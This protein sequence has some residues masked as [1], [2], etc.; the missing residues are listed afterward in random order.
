MKKYKRKLVFHTY[1]LQIE[2]NENNNLLTKYFR[3]EKGCYGP[4]G[5]LSSKF[6]S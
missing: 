3:L 1:V 5:K 2:K 4:R 6:K